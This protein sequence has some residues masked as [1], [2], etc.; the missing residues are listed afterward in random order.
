MDK[1][2]TKFLNVALDT[3]VHPASS[4]ARQAATEQKAAVAAAPA[5]AEEEL[6]AQQWFERGVNAT[7]LDEE[8]RFN[9]E[10]I[11]LKPDFAEAF[12]NRGLA[13]YKQRRLGRRTRGLQ[14]GHPPQARLRHRL[15]QPRHRA[16]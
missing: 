3:V 9:S 7:D 5:V 14:R 2:R 4:A 16:Q 8:I 11:R 6:T 10:A 13:R 15:Q 12:N 1:L